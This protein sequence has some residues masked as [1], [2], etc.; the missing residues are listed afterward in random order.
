GN[1]RA[2]LDDAQTD[3]LWKS[4][5]L[6]DSGALLYSL[7]HVARSLGRPELLNLA[8]R[9]VERIRT[10]DIAADEKLDVIYGSAGLILGLLALHEVALDRQ[11]LDLASLC[12]RHLLEHRTGTASDAGPR[13][14]RTL[15]GKLLTGFSHGAAGIGYALGRLFAATLDPAFKEGAL[16]AVAYEA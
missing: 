2:C 3:E 6:A 9:I 5:S 8:A 10:E 4:V 13:V 16:E 15:D 12:G 7:V 1:V 11:L 14:W